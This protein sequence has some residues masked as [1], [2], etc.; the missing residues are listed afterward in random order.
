MIRR[1]ISGTVLAAAACSGAEVQRAEPAQTATITIYDQGFALVQELRRVTLREGGNEVVIPGVPKA[2]DPATTAFTV[3]S[4]PKPL[5]LLEQTFSGSNSPSPELRW[6]LKSGSQGMASLRLS[7]RVDGISWS[8]AHELVMGGDGTRAH[9]STRVGLRNA[10]GGAFS[11]AQVRL[12][13]TERGVAPKLPLETG[14]TDLPPSQ[15]FVYG[16]AKAQADRLVAG[17]SAAQTYELDE[18]CSLP[19][20][21]TKFV[22]FASSD[23]LATRWLYVYDGVRFDRFQRS[24]HTDWN[25]GSECHNVVDAYVEFDN[26][27]HNDLGRTLPP[28]KLRIMKQRPGDV[29]DFLGE[30]DLEPVASNVTVHARIGPAR[31]IR[32]ERERTG[33]NEIKTAHEYEESFEIRLKNESG[34]NATVRVVEHLYRDANFDIVKAD[35]EY[36]KT[37]PQTIEFVP[38]IKSGSQRSIHYTVHYRW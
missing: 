9:F 12:V 33:Y 4:G 22:P 23:K 25:F 17:M 35:T 5:D 8:A 30:T 18:R 28:G 1:L 29:V 16:E 7:Y 11:N 19:D 21:V 15:R 32:G 2:I 31:G 37:A 10:S 3:M 13:L 27:A 38:D 24:P 6:V 20:G 36:K 26:D 14:N 34:E